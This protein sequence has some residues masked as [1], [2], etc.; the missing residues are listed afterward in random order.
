MATALVSL[1]ITSYTEG[2]AATGVGALERFLAG[3]RVA[4]NAQGARARESLVA[5]LA[6]V[7]I[8]GLREGRGR[9]WG[10]VVMVLPRVG[11]R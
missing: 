5:C 8:L 6:D 10:N 11:T 2:F 9:R 4:M 7:A 1:H 3:V